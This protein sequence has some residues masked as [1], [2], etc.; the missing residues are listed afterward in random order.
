MKKKLVLYSAAAGIA[1]ILY[2]LAYKPVGSESEIVKKNAASA[3]KTSMA[4]KAL[5]IAPEK[6]DNKISATGT[7]I[8]NEH[9][10]LRGEI[11]GRVTGIFF[12]EDSPVRKDQL[13]VKIN[14]QD[15]KAQRAKILVQKELAQQDESRKKA[16][17]GI[18]GISQDEYDQALSLV[19]SLEAELQLL[20][21]KI[22]QTEVR[23]PFDG[24]IGLRK[25]SPGSVVSPND[26]IAEIQEIDPVKIEFAIPEKYSHL[27]RKGSK[28]Y[29]KTI[30]DEVIRQGTVYA[31]SNSIDLTTRSLTVRA[32]A[33]NK[34]RSLRPGSFVKVQFVLESVDKAVVV[35]SDAIIPELGGQKVFVYQNGI[36]VGRN[37]ATGIRTDSE[38]QLLNGISFQDTLIITGLLHLK[39]SMHVRVDQIVDKRSLEISTLTN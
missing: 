14:D 33:G 25:V 12:Q 15:L 10:H 19:K 37:V 20:D 22:A 26:L 8:P 16:I 38:T 35:P 27:I 31:M 2:F 13:L 3:S 32:K 6:I 9:V 30:G 4:V 18:E 17:L 28:I 34:D 39:D 1:L 7:I 11:S 36:A 24:V 5:I 29:F 23:A 21:A